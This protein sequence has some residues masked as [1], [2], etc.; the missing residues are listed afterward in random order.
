MATPD[1]PKKPTTLWATPDTPKK[2]TT[3]WATRPI[4]TD[5]K[6]VVRFELERPPRKAPWQVG[7]LDDSKED[8]EEREAQLEQERP[9]FL[10]PEPETKAPASPK[11]RRRASS[12][13]QASPARLVSAANY[14][15]ME[16]DSDQYGLID[17]GT[18][19]ADGTRSLLVH[20]PRR[21]QRNGA[22]RVLEQ[23]RPGAVLRVKVAPSG[24]VLPLRVRYTTPARYYSPG[25]QVSSLW[26]GVD[27]P[28]WLALGASAPRI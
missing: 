23:F 19:R 1:T 17:M 13:A 14:A 8:Q 11:R 27:E 26:V 15:A 16:A 22:W 7:P 25:T 4:V 2:P 9:Q 21:A 12:G 18:N 5:K 6:R 20:V 28:G 10:L 3:P 24:P